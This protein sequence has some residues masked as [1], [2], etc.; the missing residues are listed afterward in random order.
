MSIGNGQIILDGATFSLGW[1]IGGELQPGGIQTGKVSLD[2][3]LDALKPLAATL[4]GTVRSVT[5]FFRTSTT[6]G[7]ALLFHE[8]AGTWTLNWFVAGEASGTPSTGA[9][10]SATIDSIKTLAAALAGTFQWANVNVRSS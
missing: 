2:A 1:S 3:A 8:A 5:A 4:P 6:N 10:L 7:R 9:T